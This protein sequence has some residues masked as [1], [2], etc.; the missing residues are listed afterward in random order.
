MNAARASRRVR[1]IAALTLTGAA[2]VALTG[3]SSAASKDGAYVE[4]DS[5]GGV[6][7]VWVFEGDSA[8]FANA[9]CDSLE[10]DLAEQAPSTLSPDGT[11]IKDSFGGDIYQLVW[12]KDHA[13]YPD[14]SGFAWDDHG[15]FVR[16]DADAGRAAVEK[17][18]SE[19]GKD[20]P[21]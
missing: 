14:G 12:F 4:V 6:D 3:C 8:R 5:D 17:W 9:Y 11:E 16:D 21:E 13:W 15:D 20:W 2:M 18:E 19:C 7:S 10:P 1:R